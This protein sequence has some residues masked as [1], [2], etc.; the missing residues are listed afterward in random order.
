FGVVLS[1]TVSRDGTTL[2]HPSLL[3]DLYDLDHA[4]HVLSTSIPGDL[5]NDGQVTS[6]DRLG[7]AA[8]WRRD[9]KAFDLNLN[10]EVDPEDLLGL[11]ELWRY[12]GP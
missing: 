8:E 5:D 1:G 7:I 11:I 2:V 4:G 9:S 10:E 6:A 12:Q 3:A